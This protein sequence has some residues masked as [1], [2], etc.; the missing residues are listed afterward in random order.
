[1]EAHR[2][3][4]MSLVKSFVYD[5]ET[6]GRHIIPQPEKIGDFQHKMGRFFVNKTA[7]LLG[8]LAMRIRKV[9]MHS[10]D[11]FSE[12][13]AEF[14]DVKYIEES[15]GIINGKLQRKRNKQLTVL[16]AIGGIK[17][18]ENDVM[19]LINNS[20]TGMVTRKDLWK[21]AERTVSR[22]YADF[23]EVYYYDT[24]FQTYNA[25]QLS[26]ARK[27]DYKKF[28][29]AGD[30][31]E[32]SRDFCVERAGHEFWREDGEEWNGLEWRG[33]IQG[34]DFFVQVGGYRCRHHIHWI[35][36]EK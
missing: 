20:F 34:V 6:E 10:V 22:K 1:M 16:Y 24:L 27:Y 35:K 13:G 25:A 4:L 23:F 15:I 14:K 8:E 29:Y 33:K 7:P 18:I 5:L 19:S 11:N 21:A 28:L 26:F 30:L 17:V 36:E 12:D 2:A 32:D 9:L 3:K 31:V